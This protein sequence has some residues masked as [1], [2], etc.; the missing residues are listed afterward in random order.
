MTEILKNLELLEDMYRNAKNAKES[1][2]F[3]KLAIIELCG[4][5]EETMDSIVLEYADSNLKEQ[6]NV[7]LFKKNIVEKT[8]GFEYEK[9]F[10]KMLLHL[11]GLINV[12]RIEQ[13]IEASKQARLLSTLSTLKGVRNS[14]AHTHIQGTTLSINAPS[15][16]RN[17]FDLVKEGLIAFKAELSQLKLIF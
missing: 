4:W 1:L 17:H 16:T 15:V 5:I 3:S 14:I 8:Y 12:E 7:D 11:I 9:H 13:T 6:K 2:F 10:R